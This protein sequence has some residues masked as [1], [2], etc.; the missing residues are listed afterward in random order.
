MTRKK[1]L[2]GLAFEIIERHS[3]D[4]HVNGAEIF[5]TAGK[6]PEGRPTS[7]F[8]AS[9][10]GTILPCFH[11]TQEEA[12]K[13]ALEL[14]FRSAGVK[15]GRITRTSGKRAHREPPNKTYTA[16]IYVSYM[17]NYKRCG[18]NLEEVEGIMEIEIVKADDEWKIGSV[19][20]PKG[21][22]LSK[23]VL[24][25]L[26]AASS[27]ELEVALKEFLSSFE[28]SGSDFWEEYKDVLG[29]E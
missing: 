13:F 6:W 4:P 28:S 2:D 8:T 26:T 27:Q 3:G 23:E 11:K 22:S 10:E 7:G 14:E 1:R 21:L 20:P 12:E 18:L 9:F 16:G 25:D 15:T 24:V 17:S 29:S 19:S 5:K